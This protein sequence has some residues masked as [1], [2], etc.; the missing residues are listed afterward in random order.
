MVD[1]KNFILVSIFFLGIST[2]SN[3]LDAQ[4]IPQVGF[5]TEF[6]HSGVLVGGYA[7]INFGKRLSAGGFYEV[8]TKEFETDLNEDLSVYG[9]YFGY[10]IL[11]EEKLSIGLLLRAGLSSDKFV[12][13]APS[14]S[15]GYK[16][17]QRFSAIAL[18]GFRYQR[19]STALG[20]SYNFVKP[21][22]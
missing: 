22:K 10:K 4:T 16:F 11:Q 18:L 17:S 21:G 6:T 15:F 3:N 7:G 1:M 2:T 14:F 9:G 8:R 5:M 12:L 20:I 13:I 19:N